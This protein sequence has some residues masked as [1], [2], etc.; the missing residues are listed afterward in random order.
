MAKQT[1]RKNKN[2]MRDINEYLDP[3]NPAHAIVIGINNRNLE[4]YGPLHDCGLF[5]R[6]CTCKN[7]GNDRNRENKD[8][9]K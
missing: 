4:L 7:D 1:T 6:Y 9:P 3:N 5:E 2:N 8:S